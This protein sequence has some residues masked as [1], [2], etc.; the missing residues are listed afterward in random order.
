MTGFDASGHVAEETKNARYVLLIQLPSSLNHL[1]L[2]LLPERA[3]LPVLLPRVF[4][5]LRPQYS[6]YSASLIWIPSSPY[7]RLNRLS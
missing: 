3:S 2:A 7:L 6:S 5:D 1:Y 4:S